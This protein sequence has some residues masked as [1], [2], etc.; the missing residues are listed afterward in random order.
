MLEFRLNV[1]KRRPK[2]ISASRFHQPENLLPSIRAKV[3]HPAH[4]ASL[5]PDEKKLVA[6]AIRL[7]LG[8]DD[9]SVEEIKGQLGDEVLRWKEVR[10]GT[11]NSQDELEIS[12]A[13]ANDRVTRCKSLAKVSIR[14]R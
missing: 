4:P 12:S 14:L 6:Q 11:E 1:H 10:L 3:R 5:T 13:R 9:V 8:S 7:Y 2:K